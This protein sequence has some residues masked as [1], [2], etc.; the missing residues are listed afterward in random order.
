MRTTP[1]AGHGL[2]VETTID[3]RSVF[4]LAEVTHG[5]FVHRRVW[6]VIGQ[7][8]DN[9]V[10]RSAICACDEKVVVTMVFWISHF[11]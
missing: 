11:V 2:C 7:P 3:G 8:F 6:S 5:E 4:L 10:T 9:S 1:L